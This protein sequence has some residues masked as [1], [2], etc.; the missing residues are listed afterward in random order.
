LH[1]S[2]SFILKHKKT[3]IIWTA[4]LLAGGAI[5][6][7]A[8]IQQLQKVHEPIDYTKEIILATLNI[9]PMIGLVIAGYFIGRKLDD[10][11]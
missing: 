5:A 10:N 2:L 3:I 9:L 11:S 4:G 1:D 7:Y 8:D 6:I